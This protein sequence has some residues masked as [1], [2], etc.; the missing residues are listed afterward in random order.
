M[1][2]G[3]LEYVQAVDAVCQSTH[4]PYV[5]YPPCGHLT[6]LTW[7]YGGRSVRLAMNQHNVGGSGKKWAG[8]DGSENVK[9]NGISCVH[10]GN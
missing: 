8:V 7:G 3:H 5:S 6:D 1:I 9:K 10:E 4:S 2:E